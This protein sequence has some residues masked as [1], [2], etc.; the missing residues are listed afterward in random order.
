VQAT[1]LAN[2]KQAA[3]A[4]HGQVTAAARAQAAR[5]NAWLPWWHALLEADQSQIQGMLLLVYIADLGGER[6]DIVSEHMKHFLKVIELLDHILHGWHGCL[7]RTRA[8]NRMHGGRTQQN[9]YK[10]VTCSGII[11]AELKDK[12]EV[13]EAL[14]IIGMTEPCS[15]SHQRGSDTIER[16]SLY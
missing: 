5:V 8:A 1:N 15:M 11:L 16:L 2:R 14:T 10:I 4:A 3:A 6:T 7:P 9:W 12:L 13:I